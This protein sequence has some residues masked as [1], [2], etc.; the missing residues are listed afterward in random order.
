M[1]FFFD[2][3]AY[4]IFPIFFLNLLFVQFNSSLWGKKFNTSKSAQLQSIS[5]ICF[6]FLFKCLRTNTLNCLFFLLS[7]AKRF[8][9]A[10]LAHSLHSFAHF[11]LL[12]VLNWWEQKMCV[13][14]FPIWF[15][16]SSIFCLFVLF[17]VLFCFCFWFTVFRKIKISYKYC[18]CCSRTS[19]RHS[20]RTQPAPAQPVHG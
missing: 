19:A 13:C 1:K 16:V 6:F 15:S 11:I 7:L 18:Y 2:T 4:Q 3:F 17:C 14:V 10:I 20:Q 8:L 5:L 9:F 12:N